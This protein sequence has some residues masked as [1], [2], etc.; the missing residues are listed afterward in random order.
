MVR[1]GLRVCNDPR[2]SQGMSAWIT[3]RL[4]TK[5]DAD[6]DGDV[7]TVLDPDEPFEDGRNCHYSFIG[8]GHP[9][10]PLSAD[11][12]TTAADQPKPTFKEV[13][14]QA[15]LEHLRA[16]TALLKAQIAAFERSEQRK[17]VI[18]L[19][20]MSNNKFDHFIA[21]VSQEIDRR[22]ALKGDSQ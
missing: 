3:D 12:K 8:L 22:E 21:D 18:E 10:F 7:W 11:D 20:S 13:Y 6:V 4:P 9:W 15:E 5:A 19:A 1:E 17:G 2:N 14:A 16:K